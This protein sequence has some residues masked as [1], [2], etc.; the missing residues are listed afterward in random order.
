MQNIVSFPFNHT[1][2][3]KNTFSVWKSFHIHAHIHASTQHTQTHTNTKS[4]AVRKTMRNPSQSHLLLVPSF[5]K[6]LGWEKIVADLLKY[7]KE[8]CSSCHYYYKHWRFDIEISD[9]FTG[10]VVKRNM[11]EIQTRGLVPKVTAP[12]IYRVSIAFLAQ[13][14][15]Y[16]CGSP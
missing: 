7:F 8:P 1:C 16:P 4:S 6:T 9:I 5:C 14:L 13:Y 12:N 15:H 11:F 10:T 2:I 3:F